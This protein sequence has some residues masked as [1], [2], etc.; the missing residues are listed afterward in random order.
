MQRFLVTLA[1]PLV[2]LVS[3][4]DDDPEPILAPSPSSTPTPTTESAE[5]SPTESAEPESPE[6][7]IERWI[8]LSNE[9]QLT[10]D[11]KAY[12]AVSEECR[13]CVTVA[14]DMQSIYSAEGFVETRGW[15][16][17]SIDRSSKTS[18]G[19]VLDA[20]IYSNPVTLRRSRAAQPETL[21]GG[22][23]GIRFRVSEV[24]DAWMLTSLSEIAL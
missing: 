20:R 2:L 8:K 17:R 22:P 5:P 11:T 18:D 23:I 3:C 4:S 14:D 24:N 21:P 9:M 19:Q 1:V 16:I 12:L 15:E 13:P 7:F 6:E 10:G